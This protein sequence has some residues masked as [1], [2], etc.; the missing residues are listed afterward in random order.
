MSLLLRGKRGATLAFLLVVGLVLSGLGWLTAAAL[1]LERDGQT[2][3]AQA[4]EFEKLRLALWRLDGLLAPVL[5]REDS[6]PYQ[7]YSEMFAPVAL[8]QA[9]GSSMPAGRVFEPSP[10]LTDELPDW[11]LLHFQVDALGN[12]KSPQVFSDAL[13]GRM[14]RSVPALNLVNRTTER[15]VLLG[16]LSQQLPARELIALVQAQSGILTRQ[17]LALLANALDVN[18]AQANSQMFQMQ[19]ANNAEYDRDLRNRSMRQ[20]PIGRQALKNE[21]AQTSKSGN[22]F[23]DPQ[24]DPAAQ[25]QAAPGELSKKTAGRIVSVALGPMTPFW[26]K[27][28]TGAERLFIMRTARLEGF[29]ICQGALLDWPLLE[30]ILRQ[31]VQD[32]F[33]DAT[34]SRVLDAEKPPIERTLA[35]L[36]VLLNPGTSDATP[37]QPVWSPL[38][39]GLVLAWAA[40]LI[41]LTAV[42][43]G[44]WSLLDLSERRFRFVSAVTHEL[45]TPLTTLRLY[46]DMLSGG[47]IRE[48]SQ[49][50]EYLHTLNGEADRLN[51]LVGNVLDFSCLENQ[52]P[53]L[54]PSQIDVRAILEETRQTWSGRCQEAGMEL[55]VEESEELEQTL[56]TDARLVQQILGILV[57]NASKYCG[58]AT[59]RRIRLRACSVSGQRLAFEVEDRGPGIPLLERRAIFRAFQRGKRTEVITGG[60]GLGLALAQRWAKLLG[61][62]L[63]LKP[64]PNTPGACFR[65]EIPIAS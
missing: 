53:R 34:F 39:I 61:G 29:E 59:D 62:G 57:D 33:P 32:L 10:L 11:M 13:A 2:A 40:A 45:R 25:G 23:V 47:L 37:D 5:A 6:R 20:N 9:D 4:Q 7:D 8:L 43:L 60:V 54:A 22:V 21:A 63:F 24:N 14:Q 52:K 30:S 35:S 38:R 64:T 50:Q 56:T 17:N 44:G 49:K 51:R 26:K 48:E 55:L 15:R 42:G 12:W 46:L 65:L 1:G 19:G 27:A 28:G 31:E 58:E 36:P 18:F 41:A 16:L 3:Q